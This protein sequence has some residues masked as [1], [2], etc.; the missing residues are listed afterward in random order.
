VPKSG[1]FVKI[2]HII[3]DDVQ[4]PWVGGGGALRALEINRILAKKHEITTITGNFPKAESET[5]DNIRFIRKGYGKN[6]FLSRL[7]FSLLAPFQLRRQNFD[8]IVNEFSAFSP[9][10]CHWFTRKP[11]VHTFYHILGKNTLRKFF[12]LGVLAYVFE[13]IFLATA[14]SI[15][16]ISPSVTRE[17]EKPGDR[18]KIQCIYTGI[19]P[20]LFAVESKPGEYIA[21][22]GRLDI[23]MKGLDIL[24]EA[25]SRIKDSE[26]CLKIAGS[27]PEK[28]ISGLKEIV[29]RLKLE[30][31]VEFLGRIS[32]EDKKTF[33]S[34]SY[35]TVMPSRFEGWGIS[36]IES[37]SCGKAVIGTRIPGLRDAIHDGETGIL[38]ESGDVRDL[39]SAM[40]RLLDD[41]KLRTELGKNGK[42]WA[43]N[44][45]WEKITEKQE[46]FY[47][48][49]LES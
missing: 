31:R 7:T 24:L 2:L 44:F 4:N 19:S 41:E 46:G 45:G 5:R 49:V 30:N 3:Y 48:E 21:F 39:S 34:K 25:F 18:R 1:I 16:T 38:V 28:N 36:A 43:L 29:K 33:L 20:D 47:K 13:K 15:I 26:V 10:Y 32:D 17:I 8:L 12:L 23:Y 27:G 37:S 11:V 42:I 35:F 14:R 40:A 9:C 22:L 6:Y